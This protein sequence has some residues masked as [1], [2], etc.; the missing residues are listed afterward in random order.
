M[1]DIPRSFVAETLGVTEDS[2]P[3]GDMPQ[4]RFAERYIGFLRA[5]YETEVFDAHPDHWTD[6]VMSAL[7]ESRP[8]L[9]L[10]VIC[11]VLAACEDVEEVEIVAAGPLEELMDTHGAD[12]LPE[13]DERANA[14]ARFRLALAALWAEGGGAPLLKAR[15]RAVAAP[16]DALG[17]GDLPSTEGLG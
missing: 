9:A 15:V 2:L 16:P 13:I 3:E 11:A 7:I 14:A 10:S 8:S 4:D 17:A 6:L 12:L 1:T 5:T